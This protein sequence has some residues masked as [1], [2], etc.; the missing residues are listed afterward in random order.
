MKKALAI[1]VIL[2]IL[3]PT[4][5]QADKVSKLT[6]TVVKSAFRQEA[7]KRSNY[8]KIWEKENKKVNE[9][10][11]KAQQTLNEYAQGKIKLTPKQL[12]KVQQELIKEPRSPQEIIK[13]NKNKAKQKA[14]DYRNKIGF[15]RWIG[16]K[17]FGEWVLYLDPPLQELYFEDVIDME[18]KEI[19]A[20]YENM[21][22]YVPKCSDIKEK[23]N[24]LYELTAYDYLRRNENTIQKIWR[25]L[26]YSL[27]K[28]N[29]GMTNS[30]S[31]V[32]ISPTPIG[33]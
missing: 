22:T 16:S 6:N 21:N 27:G 9:N 8:I 11:E 17:L 10:K 26:G 29:K 20:L 32:P 14:R 24:N 30:P 13:I 31:H 5:I 23:R 25:D 3:A 1:L 4:P 28:A 2:C 15:W 7:I 18:D 12:E 33:L 19:E